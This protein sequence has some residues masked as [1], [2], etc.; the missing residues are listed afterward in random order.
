MDFLGHALEWFFAAAPLPGCLCGWWFWIASRDSVS[1]PSWR[2]WATLLGLI[3]VSASIAFGAYAWMYLRWFPGPAQGRL[4]VFGAMRVGFLAAI[5]AI[6][7]SFCATL[8]TRGAL[9]LS[10]LGLAGFYFL[11]AMAA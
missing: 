4:D 10:C 3:S 2:R 5:V 1:I 6:A 7:S 11:I 8:R 9:M